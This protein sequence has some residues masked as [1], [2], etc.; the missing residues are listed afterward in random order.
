MPL[1]QYRKVRVEVEYVTQGCGTAGELLD[2]ITAPLEEASRD[3]V[4]D[5][6]SDVAGFRVVY[7]AVTSGRPG[8]V[9]S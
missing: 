9:R 3:L 4:K 2:S 8:D 6:G 7:S 5:P 1:I